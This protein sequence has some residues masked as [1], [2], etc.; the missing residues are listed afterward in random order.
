MFKVDLK[1]LAYLELRNGEF[2]DKFWTVFVQFFEDNFFEEVGELVIYAP[3][4]KYWDEKLIQGI[5]RY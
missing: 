4:F 5:D 2:C 1:N 3:F